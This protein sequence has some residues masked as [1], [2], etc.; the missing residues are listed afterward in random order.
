MVKSDNLMDDEKLRGSE[1]FAILF[2]GPKR[3]KVITKRDDWLSSASI[4]PFSNSAA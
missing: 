3:L 2:R 4:Q 1:K